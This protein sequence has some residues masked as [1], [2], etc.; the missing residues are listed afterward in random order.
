M[1]SFRR[2]A[3]LVLTT[4]LGG[5][6]F[7][8]ARAAELDIPGSYGNEKGCAYAG[9]GDFVGDDLLLLTRNEVMTFVTSC[10]FVQIFPAEA[11]SQVAIVT[12]GHEGEGETTLSMMRVQKS[13]DGVDAHLIFDQDGTMWG[14]AGRCP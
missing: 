5:V 13:Q 2:L 6:F 1:K 14:K 10:S 4:G 11:D 7:E 9:R 3:L 12:C 8:P